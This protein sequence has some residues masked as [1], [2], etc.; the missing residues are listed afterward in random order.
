MDTI[1][2]KIDCHQVKLLFY[3]LHCQIQVLAPVSTSAKNNELKL[4]RK[5]MTINYAFPALVVHEKKASLD[6]MSLEIHTYICAN[7]L[8]NLQLNRLH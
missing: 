6:K 7:G 3:E 4:H 2:N 5:K 8:C 1:I